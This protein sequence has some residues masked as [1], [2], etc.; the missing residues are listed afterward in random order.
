[1]A[2]LFTLVFALGGWRAGLSRLSDNSF[3]WHLRTG[4]LILDHGIPHADPYS[5]TAAGRRWVA[6]SW[7]AEVLYG[8]ID[9]A[10]GAFGVRLLTA[11]TGAA[12]AAVTYQLVHRLSRDRLAAVGLTL[13]AIGASFTLWSARPLFLGILAFLG[14]LWIVEVPDSWVGRRA[15]WTI[16]V[17]VWL[18]ANVHGTFSLGLLYLGLHL[19][20]RWLEGAPFWAGRERTLASAAVLCVV[21]AALNPYGPG[22]LLFPVEL[23]GRGDILKRVTEWR[24]P[25]FRTIQGLMFAGWL[26]V[27]VTCFALGR[28]RPS[29]R[30]VVVTIPFLLL[31]FWAQRNIALSPL[32][33]VAAAA[34]CVS[35]DARR[36]A[37]DSSLNRI[38][39]VA[40]VG[41]GLLWT[42]QAAGEPN[43]DYSI[44]PVTAMRWV[45]DHGLLGQR[46][47][48]DDA[49]GG[50]VI[51]RYWPAQKVFVDDR[52][53]MYPR[54]V[55]E[56]FIHFSD[57]DG[58][59]REILDRNRIDVVVWRAKAPIVG[60]MEEDPG[61]TA[62]HRDKK[63]VVLVRATQAAAEGPTGTPAPALPPG[64]EAPAAPA[65]PAAGTALDETVDRFLAEQPV[66]FSVVAR[67]LP[68]GAEVARSAG[69]KVLSA[70][71]YK[72]FVA[73]ELLRRVY[74]GTLDRAGPAAPVADGAGRTVG[75]CIRDM[76]VVSDN[77]C[78]VWG[79]GQVGSG[80]LDATLARDGFPGTS[81]A[82]P[83]QTTAADVARFFERARDGSLLGPGREAATGELYGLLRGQ[84]VNDRLPAGLPPGT[85][86]AHKTGDRIHWAHDA[87]IISGPGEVLLVVLSGPWPAPCCDADHPG[88]GES[89]AFGAI[90]ELARRVWTSLS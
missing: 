4:H 62:V 2:G 76:I 73:R 33:G 24:S 50:Y 47:M 80:R 10:V 59:W 40:L 51:L 16:P 42:A 13:A 89:R 20:G 6:Q 82:S 21:V 3:F 30:D 28:N 55:L 23:L 29:R 37:A 53:D 66:P 25:D 61:W 84:Q 87:G 86:I 74:A 52:Y 31:A 26:A 45:A 78:G 56:D 19:A 1:M 48:T 43:F 41:L 79:L 9:R 44:Y 67:R 63:A 34:R 27:F 22:L 64:R 60:L 65:A 8:A 32:V 39:A 54:P 11:I 18:W 57:A 68:S 49:W 72:L 5:F 81:L 15:I 36:P 71:L 83:Q 85:P 35:R 88:P 46:L 69:R 75:E 12:V 14:L 58:R 70:S 7:L 38:V 17:L 90:A 77:P